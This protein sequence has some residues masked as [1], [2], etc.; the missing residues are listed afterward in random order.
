MFKLPS[1]QTGETRLT[2]GFTRAKCANLQIRIRLHLQ[3]KKASTSAR[4]LLRIVKLKWDC[5][6]AS[7]S[8]QINLTLRLQKTPLWLKTEG[9]KWKCMNHFYFYL[10]RV[11][12][13]SSLMNLRDISLKNFVFTHDLLP[14]PNSETAKH[15]TSVWQ[16]FQFSCASAA[17]WKVGFAIRDS[18]LSSSEALQNP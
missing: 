17:G 1:Q 16:V 15:A 8:K 2:R 12:C 7:C 6:I 14:F 18:R 11:R 3:S 4:D 9:R 13:S 10:L 5:S